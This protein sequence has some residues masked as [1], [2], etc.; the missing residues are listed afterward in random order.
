MSASTEPTTE[1]PAPATGNVAE[2]GSIGISS[3]VNAKRSWT[4]AE[5]AQLLETVAKLGATNWSRI[6]SQ[7]TDRMGKQ[8]RER[9]FNH[10]C[11]A[12]KKGEWT[13]EEDQLIADGVTELGTKWSEIVKRLPGRTDNAIKNRYNSMLKRQQRKQRR[14]LAEARGEVFT[15][16]AKRP[17]ADGAK[18]PPKRRKAERE[19][20]CE[21]GEADEADL[22]E[23]VFEGEEGAETSNGSWYERRRSKILELATS[24]ACEDSEGE[25][26]ALITELMGVTRQQAACATEPPFAQ[27][28]SFETSASDGLF[29]ES[30]AVLEQGVEEL[31][32]AAE[33]YESSRTSSRQTSRT[34]SRSSSPSEL[35]LL[36]I[37][38]MGG[39]H[40]AL[41]QEGVPLGA[42]GGGADLT[43]T[44]AGADG[45]SD[46]T[47]T[48][49]GGADS[50]ADLTIGVTELMGAAAG[51]DG[52]SPIGDGFSPIMRR[53]P[54]A[55]PSTLG[56]AVFPQLEQEE[57]SA[58]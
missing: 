23:S 56:A 19:Q 58:S 26:D 42:A 55:S 1:L 14:E 4:E 37:E 57:I 39:G 12:V 53:G 3:K 51:G 38:L 27:W 49:G 46:L 54:S 40:L 9:W 34:S 52:F 33:A 7:L 50:D 15:T 47:V 16:G 36:G 13:E 11:P 8:C 24:L 48:I 35:D 6:A 28:A 10:L 2:H 29:V 30:A 25:R 31:L 45:D 18:R 17:A 41:A 22:E 43:V 44:L 20:S 32:S 5:D 21:A